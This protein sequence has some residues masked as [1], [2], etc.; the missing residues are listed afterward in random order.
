MV[1][2][3]YIVSNFEVINIVYKKGTDNAVAACLP[4]RSCTHVL[5]ISHYFLVF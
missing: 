1:V 3:M 2:N 4:S 5:C